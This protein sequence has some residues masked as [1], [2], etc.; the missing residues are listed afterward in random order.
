VTAV[1]AVGDGSDAAGV[2]RS[3]TFGSHFAN[4]AVPTALNGVVSLD[5]LRP[6]IRDPVPIWLRS[7]P[8]SSSGSNATP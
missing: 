8:T 5:S 1:L 3:R 6:S 2:R 4:N 7:D